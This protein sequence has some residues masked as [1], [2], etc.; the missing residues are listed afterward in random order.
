MDCQLYCQLLSARLAFFGRNMRKT[1][2]P[3]WTQN[4]LSEF[5]KYLIAL[6]TTQQLVQNHSMIFIFGSGLHGKTVRK[7]K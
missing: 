6:R 4:L 2:S 7:T 5:S 1:I 3:A